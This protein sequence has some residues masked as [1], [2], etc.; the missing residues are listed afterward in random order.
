MRITRLIL[1]GLFF[2]VKAGSFAQPTEKKGGEIPA[3]YCISQMEYKLYTMV[4]DYRARFDL[5]PI[6]LSKSLCFVA[7]T[8]VKDLFLNHPDRGS[9]NSHSWSSNGHWKPFC[10]PKDENKKN[11]VWDK[12][13]ELTKYRGKGYEIVY[14]ENSATVI[15]SIIEFW[16]SVD[17]FNS[18]LMNTGKWN[19]KT[20]NAI[21]IAIYENYAA[22]WF[23]E[24]P[25]PEGTPLICGAPVPVKEKK[26]VP[27][28]KESVKHVEPA[29]VPKSI[30]PQPV[31]EKTPP[32]PAK[33]EDVK[34]EKGTKGHKKPVEPSPEPTIQNN[35]TGRY[36]I[37]VK[38]QSPRD[39]MIKAMDDMKKEGFKDI[40][41]L[42]KDSKLRLSVCDFSSKSSADSALKEIKKSY[43]DAWIY[44]F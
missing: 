11:S 18:F 34:K 21:G 42:E 28:G 38:S 22:A 31:T 17:Y 10:Y 30:D 1:I 6:P 12:P 9:C 32:G 24:L 16:K 43:K 41:M 39:E 3:S 5:P 44:K 27:S 4:N 2:L 25:D 40:K 33:K 29:P 14:W 8:H 20:W 35:P 23:G 7:S 37:I 19:G 15:D 26:E 13:K 36:Y